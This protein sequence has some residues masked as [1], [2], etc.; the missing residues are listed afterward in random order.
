MTLNFKLNIYIICIVYILV[1]VLLLFAAPYEVHLAQGADASSWYSP[2]LSLLK[3]GEFVTLNDPSILQTYRPPLYP[4]YEAFMLFIGNGN[5]ISIIIGQ[6]L[7][8]W[9]AG[10]IT[11]RMVEKILPSRGIVGLVLVVFNPNALGT[12]H[13][14]QSDILYMFMVTITLYYLLLYSSRGSCKLSVL[15][16]LLFGLSCLVRTSGQ[17]LIPLFPIIYIIVGLLQ[18]KKQP[19]LTHLYRGL[20]SIIFAVAVVFPWVQHN[21]SAGWGYNLTT[22]E[23][24]SV[25][26]KDNVIYLESI[27]NNISLN[28]AGNKITEDEQRH[29]SSYAEKWLQMSKQEKSSAI[30]DYYKK[31]IF[32]YDYNTV[33]KGFI[34]SWIGLF[35]A[36]GA[37]NLHNILALDSDS[38]SI[39]VMANAERHVGRMEAVFITLLKSN[40]V[41]I[42]IS[43]ISFIYV[44]ILRIFGLVGLIMMIKDKEYGALFIFTGVITYFVLIALF[45]G[46]SRYR[47]PI[48]SALIIMAVYGFISIAKKSKTPKIGNN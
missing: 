36:G 18:E 19:I 6:I 1:N 16:G 10:I 20:I 7:L 29:I 42:I 25:Y 31:R 43:L 46:N 45:V 39:Q 2:A 17:Y 30:V 24:E 27:L 11:Y 35:G 48:E 34:D 32:T 26:F 9:F 28:N 22:S 14:V 47:L 3:H 33:T 23:I 21:A 38:S 41:I 37:A 40:L 12:A 8:L 5:I 13:L 44:I 4:I 15:I